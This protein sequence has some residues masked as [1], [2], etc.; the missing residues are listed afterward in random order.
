MRP[1]MLFPEPTSSPVVLVQEDGLVGTSYV[2]GSMDNFQ[3]AETT[4]HVHR[5]LRSANP[6]AKVRV[7]VGV[8]VG[9]CT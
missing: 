1:S 3:I 4:L 9:V 6:S 7:G 2:R 8:Q 5:V